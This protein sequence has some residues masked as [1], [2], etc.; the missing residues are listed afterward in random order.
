MARILATNSVNLLTK[1]VSC[2]EEV[3]WIRIEL[4]KSSNHLIQKQFLGKDFP[5]F[6]SGE[7]GINKRHAFAMYFQTA[8]DIENANI[9]V[10]QSN[11]QILTKF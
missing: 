1:N 7:G 9:M 4:Q 10:N 11:K 6:I 5:Y 2:H 3:F 8:D